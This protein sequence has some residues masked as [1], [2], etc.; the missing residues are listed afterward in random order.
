MGRNAYLIHFNG[1]KITR[2]TKMFVIVTGGNGGEKKLLIFGPL[3]RNLFVYFT[4]VNIFFSI[5]Q[6]S[7]A[8]TTGDAI[9]VLRDVNLR[10]G[11]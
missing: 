7:K 8:R 9:Y 5:I 2:K 6:S 11:K 3:T 10:A 4:L 1:L